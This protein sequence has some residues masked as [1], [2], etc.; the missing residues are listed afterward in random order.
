VM[1]KAVIIYD[2]ECNYCAEKINFIKSRDNKGLFIY[3]PRNSAEAIDLLTELSADYLY[4]DS[5]FLIENGI[6]HI[7]SEAVLHI[8]KILGGFWKILM[9]GKLIPVVARDHIYDL[10]ARHRKCL[11][12][13]PSSCSGRFF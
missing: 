9:I 10:F 6:L 3:L 4:R 13:Y 12:K 8:I 5:V 11:K 1:E 2:S 7:K